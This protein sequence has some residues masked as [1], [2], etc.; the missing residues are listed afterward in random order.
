MKPLLAIWV[1][2]VLLLHQDIW[3]WKDRSLV[4]GSIPIGLAY[5]AGY[6]ILAAITMALLVRFFW[7]GQL[8]EEQVYVADS[9]ISADP[10]RAAAGSEARL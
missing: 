9:A 3:F 2:L 4:F 6:A 1:V 7:P 10:A 8:E 5:H